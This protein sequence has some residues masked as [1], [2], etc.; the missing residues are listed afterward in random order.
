MAITTYSE[1]QTAAANWLV[2]S[3]LTARIPEFIALAEARLART[4]RMR[5]GELDVAL[6]GTPAARTIALPSAYTEALAC[7]ITPPGDTMRRELKFVDP[8]ALVTDTQAGQPYGWTID[9][10]TLAFERPL[11]QAYSFTLRCLEKFSLSDAAPTNALL[12]DCPDVYLFGL[13]C[14]AAP[15]LRDADLAQAYAAKLETAITEINTK[16]ARSRAPQKLG[17]EVGQ[18]QKLQRPSSYSITSDRP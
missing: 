5:R 16:E 8:A 7:W 18:M 15:F 3:D 1:L 10:S 4:L 17:T 6:T 9:G 2:R 12:T 11:D 14:E 13:L